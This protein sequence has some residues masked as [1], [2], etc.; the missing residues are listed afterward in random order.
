MSKS[1]TITTLLLFFYLVGYAQERVG[2][3]TTTPTTTLDVNG[4]IKISTTEDSPE[5]GSIRWNEITGDFEGYN[6]DRWISLTQVNMEWG[7][8]PNESIESIILT[9]SLDTSYEFGKSISCYNNKLVVGEPGGT[10]DEEFEGRVHIYDIVG[11]SLEL[12]TILSVPNGNIRNEFGTKVMI[13]GNSIMIGAPKQRTNGLSRGAVY[14]Y[15]PIGGEWVQ[16]EKF[17]PSDTQELTGFGGNFDFDGENLIVGRPGYDSN[18]FTFSGSATLFK[19]TL[20]GWERSSLY[21]PISPQD[22]A[23]YGRGV[24]I[25]GN[26][27]LISAPLYDLDP[28]HPNTGIVYAYKINQNSTSYIGPI[29]PNETSKYFGNYITLENNNAF[30]SDN[31]FTIRFWK[32][33]NQSWTQEYGYLLEEDISCLKSQNGKILAGKKGIL[34][35]LE[36]IN[37]RLHLSYIFSYFSTYSEQNTDAFYQDNIIGFSDV[38]IDN[39]GGVLI[40]FRR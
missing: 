12:D 29:P 18:G 37:D 36:P 11:R 2:I 5:A 6:G 22:M 3:N 17:L 13:I 28:E 26:N 9:T 4:M 33:Q 38:N 35:M 24:A 8:I 23:R 39:Q 40:Y 16:V 31:D 30:I 21:P 25:S 14:L 32:N 1:R 7:E 15:R 27:L 19:R 20:T 34:S 10:Y